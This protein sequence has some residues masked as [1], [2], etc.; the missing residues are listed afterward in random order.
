MRSAMKIAVL[1]SLVVAAVLGPSAAAAAQERPLTV[2]RPA[3]PPLPTLTARE[4]RW[5]GRLEG[6][7]RRSLGCVMYDGERGGE[8]YSDERCWDWYDRLHASGAGG[9]HASGRVLLASMDRGDE[10]GES[11]VRLV[12]L[13]GGSERR[14]AAP[15]LL[16]LLARGQ[17]DADAGVA[18][19]SAV[20]FAL[21][22]L[23]QVDVAPV[24]P[25]ANRVEALQPAAARAR[26]LDAWL[27][28][29]A[30]A[31]PEPY[32]VW[33]RAGRELAEAH[34]EDADPAIRFEAI[35]RLTEAHREHHAIVASL[36]EML[37]AP[38]LPAEARRYVTRYAGRH[39]LMTRREIRELLASV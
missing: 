9:V 34:L 26:V 39:G 17:G 25:W 6:V 16:H 7:A 4:A 11:H 21:S 28:W 20:L 33:A 23:A 3:L 1:M 19:T 31:S 32:R 2:A 30:A 27:T 24:A 13:L 10:L 5:V 18:L 8:E 38:E 22:D 37:V 29:H 15:Y 14:V 12:N 35:R 36:R